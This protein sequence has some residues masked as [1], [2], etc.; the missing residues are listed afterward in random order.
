MKAR[1]FVELVDFC[2]SVLPML[3]SESKDQWK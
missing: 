1:V 3:F 2:V